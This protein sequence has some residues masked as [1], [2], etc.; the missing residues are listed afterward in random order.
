[1][2]SFTD[3]GT[4][5]THTVVINW[6]D[7]S[8]N[9]TVSLAANVLSFSNVSH[10]YLDNPAGGSSYTISVTVTHKDNGS[11]SGSTAV[12]V[13]HV[14]PTKVQPSLTTSIINYTNLTPL[15]GS[16]TDP[17]TLDTHTVVIDWGD[18]S[19]DT[20]NL[21]AGVLSFSNVSHQYL[22]NPAGGSYGISVT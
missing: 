19:S 15:S 10:Q 22:D 14:A 16:F 11:D 20:L 5:D 12:T 13:N 1:S 9:T 7:G 8:A 3:P 21:N 18:N 17:G 6:G 4:L 2:G